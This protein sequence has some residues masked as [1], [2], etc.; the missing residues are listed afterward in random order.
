METPLDQTTQTH[1]NRGTAWTVFLVI[2]AIVIGTSLLNLMTT[3][4]FSADKPI[5]VL[6]LVVFPHLL[7]LGFAN[8]AFSEKRTRPNY[9]Y[10]LLFV[11]LNLFVLFWNLLIFWL[12]D[13][14]G[15]KIWGG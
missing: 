6:G 13:L 8:L 12:R 11:G 3:A 14:G 7:S 2:E 10:L 15:S 1:K 4:Y 5:F 9:F